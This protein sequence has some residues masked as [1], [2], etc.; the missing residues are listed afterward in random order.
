[1]PSKLFSKAKQNH[2]LYGILLKFHNIVSRI[3]PSS[4]RKEF[5]LKSGIAEKETA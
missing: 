1:M 3:L 2:E 5:L 4:G